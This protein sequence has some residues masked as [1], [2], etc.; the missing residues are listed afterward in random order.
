M[1]AKSQ[2]RNKWFV[3]AIANLILIGAVGIPFSAMPVLFSSITRDLHLTL[4]QIGMIWGV[5]PLGGVFAAI[6]GG[7][8]GDRFDTRKMIGIGCFVIAIISGLRG[9]SGNFV[10]LIVFMF[11]C[12]IAI[13]AVIPNFTKVVS[14]LFPPRQLGL[15]MGILNTGVNIGG[16]LTTALGATFILPL[17]GTWRN[18][19]FLYAVIGVILGIIWLLAVSN[20]KQSHTIANTDSIVKK[21][22][23]YKTLGRIIR[24]KNMWLL[25]VASMLLAG[26]FL[27]LLGYMPIYLEYTGVPK[28][29]GDTISSTIFTAGILGS[30]VIPVLSDRIG[31]RKIV[32]LVC[33]III[34]VS[35][36]LL[37]ISDTTFF[38]ILI[39]LIGAMFMGA[40]AVS[41]AIPLEMKEIG[42]IYGSSAAGIL[43]ASHNIGGFLWPLLGGKLAEI[44]HSWPFIFWAMLV[45]VATLCLLFIDETS[46]KSYAR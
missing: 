30:L 38:W 14:L 32:L 43:I 10:T 3:L 8:L 24:L 5:L 45:L 12:G 25:M 28:S 23:V 31:S 4:A 13:T 40:I 2:E 39:P 44:N 37:S 1:V 41:I 33:T 26:S 42:P 17:V 11:L 22:S 21:D 18:V 36:Y 29:T 16:I 20:I 9:I 46:Q 7:L 35:I 15:A 34:G 19:L 6:P 27:A